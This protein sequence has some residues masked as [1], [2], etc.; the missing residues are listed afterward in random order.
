MKKTM[1]FIV[2]FTFGCILAGEPFVVMNDI[3]PVFPERDRDK[4]ENAVI[5]G[6]VHFLQ[7]KSYSDLLLQEYEK[8][9]KQEINYAAA[10]D[11]VEKA[12]V[13]LEAAKKEYQESIA[14]GNLAGYAAEKVQRF[15]VFDYDK[16][17][18]QM[19]LNKDLMAVVKSYLSAGN[20][21]GAYQEN[22]NN[23]GKIL[24]TMET[25]KEKI[26]VN[27]TPD[28]SLFWQLLQQFSQAALFGNYC[29][30]TAAAILQ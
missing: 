20:I 26:E 28:I 16:F 24:A 12:V 15:K 23:I 5:E 17:S 27:I 13:E 3:V 30:A 8:S 29:T 9:A 14:A 11:Y 6:A 2:L 7:A 21:L 1:F 19:D 10:L 25:I 18:T 4:I 22:V